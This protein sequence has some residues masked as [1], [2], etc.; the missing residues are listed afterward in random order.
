M[1]LLF[2]L[3]RG[4]AFSPNLSQV[5]RY[6]VHRHLSDMTLDWQWGSLGSYARQLAK[7]PWRVVVWLDSFWRGPHT[8]KQTFLGGWHLVAHCIQWGVGAPL[9]HSLLGWDIILWE[10]AAY[11]SQLYTSL[12]DYPWSVR[13]AVL[14]VA[15]EMIPFLWGLP[16]ANDCLRWGRGYK[17]LSPLASRWDKSMVPS[18]LQSTWWDQAEA[19]L[20]LD[21]IFAWLLLSCPVSLFSLLL[22]VLP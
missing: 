17:I 16:T 4:L 20:Q 6:A 22:R 11:G 8:E 18:T 9:R 14:G 2:I 19:R 7:L 21:Y 10:L 12:G 1:L 3:S 15:W 5:P 13:A